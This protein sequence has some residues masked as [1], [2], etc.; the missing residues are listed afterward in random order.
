MMPMTLQQIAECTDGRLVGEDLT[1]SSISTDTRTIESGSLFLAL[2]GKNFDGNKFASDAVAKGAVAVLVSEEQQ[3]LA[4]SQVV[5]T[6]TTEA[7]GKL[8]TWYRR[9]WGNAMVAITGSCGK[10]TVKGMVASILSQLNTTWATQGNLN[11]HIGVPKTLLSLMPEHH[12]AVVEMGAS[13][14]GEIEYL[15]NMAEPQ[16]ALV[17][18]V[19][20][21]HLEGFGSVDAIAKTKGEIYSGLTDDGTAIINLDDQYAGQWLQSIGERNWIGFSVADHQADVSASDVQIDNLGRA[22]FQLCTHAG[23]IEIQLNVLGRANVANALAAACCAIPLGVELND[24]KQGLEQFNAVNGRLNVGRA[25]NGA[26]LI[27]DSYNA[28]PGSVKAAIDV[29][30]EL[31]GRRILVLGDMGELADEAEAAHREVGRY[32]KNED[33][34]QLLTVGPLSNFA[35]QEFGEGAHNFASREALIAALEPQLSID[36]AVLVKG[37]RSAGMEQVVQAI[38]A[39]GENI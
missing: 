38:S 7:L 22:Q 9:R 13:G 37:S 19:V 12:F 4:A 23:R 35:V 39:Q 15:T 30:A 10:T 11:N 21:A 18:N 34:D 27:D 28:N 31:Q 29:L 1:I 16:V 36:A 3:D 25:K 14:L 6:D 33:V 26:R 2:T 32:A 24:I 17:N 5:V 8:A 20:P